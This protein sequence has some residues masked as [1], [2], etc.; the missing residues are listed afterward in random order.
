MARFALAVLLLPAVLLLLAVRQ[1]AAAGACTEPS[2]TSVLPPLWPVCAGEPLTASSFAGDPELRTYA[3]VEVVVFT[4]V[5]P[6]ALPHLYAATRFAGSSCFGN[7][8]QLTF[9]ETAGATTECLNEVATH[10]R[11]GTA[12]W[13]YYNHYCRPA[14]GAY[15]T[16]TFSVRAKVG[17]FAPGAGAPAGP[18]AFA[19]EANGVNTWVLWANAASPEA[20]LAVHTPASLGTDC[21]PPTEPSVLFDGNAT[22]TL[23]FG[24]LD[25]A[26]SPG[27]VAWQPRVLTSTSPLFLPFTGPATLVPSTAT[28]CGLGT[29]PISVNGFQSPALLRFD[30]QI[31]LA[32]SPV[33][34]S[35][36]YLGCV[37]FPLS[38]NVSAP[39]SLTAAGGF[40]VGVNH[41]GSCTGGDGSNLA[42]DRA[43]S[44]TVLLFHATGSSAG[45]YTLRQTTFDAR[46]SFAAVSAAARPPPAA[47]PWWPLLVVVLAAAAV[48]GYV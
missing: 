6:P 24:C 12:L 2:R 48:V 33:A 43:L 35:Q 44:R 40:A 9:D 14:G 28:V 17:T 39:V 5:L 20:A 42:A 31:Y 18:I 3:G 27:A 15:D 10:F 47:V 32:V 25:T 36:D 8:T 30:G 45:D 29:P 19:A 13:I 37:L 1:A 38:A 11:N 22:L 46:Q 7:V 34:A 41:T 23:V 16:E 21:Y 4:A 26:R